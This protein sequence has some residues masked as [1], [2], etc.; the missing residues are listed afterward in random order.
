MLTI[1]ATLLQLGKDHRHGFRNPT[2]TS[3]FLHRV[4]AFRV[5][6]NVLLCSW[7]TGVLIPTATRGLESYIVFGGFAKNDS[8]HFLEGLSLLNSLRW[9]ISYYCG[10]CNSDSG[11]D[12]IPPENTPTWWCLSRLNYWCE[13][14]NH[15][16]KRAGVELLLFLIRSDSLLKARVISDQTSWHLHGGRWRVKLI[17]G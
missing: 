11:V 7:R 14:T 2:P 5:S 3:T 1:T 4:C 6:P 9:F 16:A 17:H 10:W 8:W 15:K 13:S 12:Q